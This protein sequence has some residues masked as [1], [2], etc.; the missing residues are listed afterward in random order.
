MHGRRSPA[1]QGG[2]H[3]RHPTRRGASSAVRGRDPRG[4]RQRRPPLRRSA[5]RLLRRL[6]DLCGFRRCARLRR[7]GALPPRRRGRQRGQAGRA[8][9][10]AGRLR[11][12]LCAGGGRFRHSSPA[13]G[14]G[15]AGQGRA[16]SADRRRPV[17]SETRN[18]SRRRALDCAGAQ[19]AQGSL[20]G[21]WDA[22]GGMGGGN[23]TAARRGATS[24]RWWSVWCGWRRWTA[25]SPR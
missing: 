16:R 10:R 23:T 13:V 22:R 15:A 12:R 18:R 11:R 4:V 21:R 25:V 3:D 19:G 17:R 8:H 2:R 24:P 5:L 1:R 6:F 20:P 14:G 9:G 7:G